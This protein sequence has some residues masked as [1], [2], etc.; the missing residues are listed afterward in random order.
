MTS[1][2]YLSFLVFRGIGENSFA[3]FSIDQI[4]FIQSLLIVEFKRNEI[5][6]K[7]INEKKIYYW[8]SNDVDNNG[9][10]ILAKNFCF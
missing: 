5:I 9:E 3:V 10:G 1:I 4:I 6:K 7:S 2:F 8:A